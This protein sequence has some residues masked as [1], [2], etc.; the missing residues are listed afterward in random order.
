[1][2]GAD[3]FKKLLNEKLDLANYLKKKLV[4]LNGPEDI[5]I[6]TTDL[7]IVCFRFK[8]ENTEGNWIQS[9]LRKPNEAVEKPGFDADRRFFRARSLEF[10]P[11]F[12]L[13]PVPIHPGPY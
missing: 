5:E 6:I 3:E 10:A 2:Y 9:G 8:K 1:M 12:R 4:E 13:L 11:T 7:S